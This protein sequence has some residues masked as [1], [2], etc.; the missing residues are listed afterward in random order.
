MEDFRET[1]VES[2]ENTFP[3]IYLLIPIRDTKSVQGPKT[4]TL[5]LSRYHK[6]T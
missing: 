1:T 5:K 4:S 3:R 2:P 6:V